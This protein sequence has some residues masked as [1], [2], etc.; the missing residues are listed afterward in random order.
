MTAY[1]MNQALIE[2]KVN[3]HA[4]GCLLAS[5]SGLVFFATPHS[6]GNGA[7]V[8]DPAANICSVLTGTAKN[9][10]L[11]TLSKN[12]L[13]NEMTTDHFR[14]QLNDY[15]VISFFETR[16]MGVKIHKWKLLPQIS[17]VC[18]CA[19]GARL[20]KDPADSRHCT[21]FIFSISL[22]VAALLKGPSYENC[23]LY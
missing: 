6:G 7:G 13:Y 21:P 17:M 15:D 16:N 9:S 19:A 22:F 12:S 18:C 2:A 8:A 20:R 1:T 10:L 3:I 14:T 11:A 5:T 4:Y 23:H